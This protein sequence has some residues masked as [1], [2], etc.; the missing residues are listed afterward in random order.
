MMRERERVSPEGG[1][2]VVTNPVGHG[3]Q[4]VLALVQRGH[5]E[6]V[7]TLHVPLLNLSSRIIVMGD[8]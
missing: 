2:P 4:D 6:A 7:V 8:L 3:G 5:H 1:Y